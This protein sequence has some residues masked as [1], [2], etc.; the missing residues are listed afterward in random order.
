[1]TIKKAAKIT[2]TIFITI[3]L[4][5]GLYIFFAWFETVSIVIASILE[6]VALF[7]I[8]TVLIYVVAKWWEK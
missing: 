3:G 4:L 2:L 1:M 7:M 8:V 5:V 6:L